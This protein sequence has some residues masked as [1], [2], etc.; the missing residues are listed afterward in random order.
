MPPN[1]VSAFEINGV[2]TATIPVSRA[3]E[4]LLA[5]SIELVQTY[6]AKPADWLLAF[7]ITSSKL[8]KVNIGV[9][10]PNGS[11][12]ARGNPGNPGPAGPTGQPGTP[13]M[14]GL[15]GNKGSSGKPGIAGPP[16]L[17]GPRGQ[18]GCPK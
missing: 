7:L 5:N 15:P 14:D 12:G 8:L 3:S 9:K 11:Q 18:P 17:P 2:L 4:V 16:G 6:P 10:G 13:G 1:G